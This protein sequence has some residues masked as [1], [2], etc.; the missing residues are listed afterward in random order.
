[1]A[2][3]PPH[4]KAEEHPIPG[5]DAATRRTGCDTGSLAQETEES[6]LMQTK[7]S[8]ASLNDH[9][10]VASPEQGSLVQAVDSTIQSGEQVSTLLDAA[11]DRP[12][13]VAGERSASHLADDVFIHP[14]GRQ[15]VHRAPKVDVS[16]SSAFDLLV[17]GYMKQSSPPNRGLLLHVSIPFSNKRK[18]R[19]SYPQLTADTNL[20]K[21]M[22][23]ADHDHRAPTVQYWYLVHIGF[24]YS[25]EQSPHVL[26]GPCPKERIHR[27]HD[28]MDCDDIP[29]FP[30]RPLDVVQDDQALQLSIVGDEEV[31]PAGIQD[32]IVHQP[33]Q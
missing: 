25:L 30:R 3:T 16:H 17:R 29:P 12:R 5:G 8:I 26:V 21:Q 32:M 7:G 31:A 13:P 14:F 4:S 23:S 15:D 6:G 10:Q 2:E 18:P 19:I 24:V 11:Q 22:L 33:I 1:M 28:L 20:T 27:R 9:D